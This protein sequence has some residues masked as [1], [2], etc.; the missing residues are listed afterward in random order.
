MATLVCL[1]LELTEDDA[2]EGGGLGSQPHGGHRG[3]GVRDSTNAGRGEGAGASSPGAALPTSPSTREQQQQQAQQLQ[4][5]GSSGLAGALDEAH[6][7]RKL[8]QERFDP[9]RFAG[10]FS[11]GGSGA[12]PWLN[13]LISEPGEAMGGG[14]GVGLTHAMQSTACRAKAIGEV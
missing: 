11:S 2:M 6:F 7:L 1:W 4:R 14:K 13:D 9:G 12:P 3:G 5:R 10:I 8:A